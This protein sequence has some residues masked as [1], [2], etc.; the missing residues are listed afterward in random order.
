MAESTVSTVQVKL[1]AAVNLDARCEPEVS[2]LTLQRHR[3]YVEVVP[4]VGDRDVLSPAC[5]HSR[6][7]RPILT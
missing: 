3:V 2:G 4:A 5:S 7:R 6:L 1:R